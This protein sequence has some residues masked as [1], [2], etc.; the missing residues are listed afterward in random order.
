[1]RAPVSTLVPVQPRGSLP[2]IF[3][4]PGGGGEL[5]VFNALARALGPEQ[6]VYVL[7]MYVFDEIRLPSNPIS[8]EDIAARMLEDIRRVQPEGPY[9]LVGY[10]LGG[11]IVLEIAQQLRAVGEEVPMLVLLDC[12]GPGYPHLQPFLSRTIAHLKHASAMPDGALRYLAGRIKRLTRYVLPAK[13][14]EVDLFTNEAEADLIP[15]DVIDGLEAVLTP[16]VEAWERYVPRFYGG[17]VVVV[18]AGI[19]MNLVGIVDD[20]PCLGWGTVLGGTLRLEHMACN[21]FDLVRPEYAEA[22]AEILLRS[23]RPASPGV[24]AHHDLRLAQPA[25]AT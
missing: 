22:L 12:D 13:P 11:N 14:T 20:D 7:D 4:A 23:R 3:F 18:R 5:F 15:V 17:P 2:P 10:S 21:H 6:P 24:G 25:G 19:R 9:H 16:V 1:V 8:L